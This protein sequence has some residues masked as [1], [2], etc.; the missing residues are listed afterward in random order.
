MLFRRRRP[1]DEAKES[2]TAPTPLSDTSSHN[3]VSSSEITYASIEST[4]AVP[5]IDETY[6]NANLNDYHDN[7]GPNTVI[8]SEL[9]HKDATHVR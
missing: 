7:T 5:A 2:Y 3:N 6:A 9:V 4:T 8:Y 1:K